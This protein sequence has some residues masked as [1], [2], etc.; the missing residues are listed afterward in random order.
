MPQP[1][2]FPAIGLHI[3]RKRARPPFAAGFVATPLAALLCAGWLPGCAAFD[4]GEA[5]A[6]QA[7]SSPVAIEPRPRI[8]LV[9]GSGGPR[10]YA[11]IGVL[12]VLEEAGIVPDLVVGSSVGA[13]VGAFWAS[14]LSATEIDE[15][16][17]RDCGG[18]LGTP[19][20]HA[21]R[22][23]GRHAGTRPAAPG[24]HRPPGCPG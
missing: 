24:A 11:H 22:R 4:Y 1:S 19:G 10:G 7:L 16:A 23:L 9:L 13:L 14:G 20:Q 5:D 15:R 3:L 21:G 12:T 8:A 17:V 2:Q 18:C 6:P